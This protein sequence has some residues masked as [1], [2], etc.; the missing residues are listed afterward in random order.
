MQD[1]PVRDALVRA[2]MDSARRISAAIYRYG[3]F[4][5]QAAH[6]AFASIPPN[7][8]R[9]GPGTDAVVFPICHGEGV[10]L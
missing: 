4:T 1:G 5:K 10:E 7:A 9:V 2:Q 3:G 8:M 6:A